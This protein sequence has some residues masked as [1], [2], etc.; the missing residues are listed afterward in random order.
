[1]TSEDNNKNHTEHNKNKKAQPDQ[2]KL[3]K[4]IGVT[5]SVDIKASAWWLQTWSYTVLTFG[6]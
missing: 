2:L 6:V 1:M 3:T 5:Q 4:S